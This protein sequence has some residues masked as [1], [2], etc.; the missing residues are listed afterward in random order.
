VDRSRVCAL[1]AGVRGPGANCSPPRGRAARARAIESLDAPVRLARGLTRFIQILGRC[2]GR[3]HR[4]RPIRLGEIGRGGS[5]RGSGGPGRAPAAARAPWRRRSADAEDE[6]TVARKRMVGT[7]FARADQGSPGPGGDRARSA[8]S[9]TRINAFAYDDGPLPIGCKTISRPVV[10]IM[11]ELACPPGRIARHRHGVGYQPFLA[12]IERR[13]PRSDLCPLAEE[14]AA[15]LARRL[16]GCRGARGGRYRSW[17]GAPLRYDHPG[18]GPRSCLS[19]RRGALPRALI[20]RSEASA[21]LLVVEAPAGHPPRA[22]SSLR[23]SD[24]AGGA[25]ID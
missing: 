13:S 20:C 19:R 12:E 24:E 11:T 3:I 15:R 22:R 14:A 1:T 16:P 4:G 8:S 17:P 23:L 10:A 9:S 2:G 7:R 6:T 5:R 18:R 21:R 25:G